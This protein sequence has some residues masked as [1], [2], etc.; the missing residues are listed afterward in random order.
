MFSRCY[1]MKGVLQDWW[2]NRHF[3]ESQDARLISID[4]R[5]QAEYIA[6][7]AKNLTGVPKLKTLTPLVFIVVGFFEIIFDKNGVP[8][9]RQS[10]AHQYTP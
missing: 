10:F 7:A 3:C 2:H 5:E 1:Y 6:S 9:M 8:E 4:S